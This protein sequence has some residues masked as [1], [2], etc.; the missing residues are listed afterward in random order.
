MDMKCPSCGSCGM[1]MEKPE[2]FGGG[3]ASNTHCVHCTNEQGVLL[4]YEVILKGNAEYYQKE[5]GLDQEAA[6]KY[7]TDFLGSLP[8]W[9]NS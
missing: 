2:H 7:A 3:E 8:T 6:L 4:P 1:P 9:K 5:Q